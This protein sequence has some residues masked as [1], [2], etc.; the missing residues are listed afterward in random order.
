[1]ASTPAPVRASIRASPSD[2][3]DAVRVIHA[4]DNG[5]PRGDGPM[6]R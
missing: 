3:Q 4:D 2:G 5:R 1:V 6:R